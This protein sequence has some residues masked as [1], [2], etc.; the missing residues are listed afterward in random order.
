M[1]ETNTNTA[2]LLTGGNIGDTKTYLRKAQKAI[3]TKCGPVILQ[4]S[5]FQ[6]AAWGIKNQPPFINQCLVVRTKLSAPALLQAI[7]QIEKQLG[8]ER[9]VRYGPRTIDI[10][11]I[12]FN[13]EIII[14]PGLQV[15]HPQMQHRRFVL[16]C[17]NDVAPQM[18]H[19]QLHK[20]ITQLLAECTDP[21]EV[22]KIC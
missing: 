16:Q 7:L 1:E 4:S 2:F 17:I 8:R 11:I 22:H 5:L 3:E 12:F 14:Q 15:P 6:S 13:N 9:E 21:L 18:K 20:T 19:P 10:D